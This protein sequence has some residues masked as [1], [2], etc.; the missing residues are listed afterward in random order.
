MTA[1]NDRGNEFSDLP[2]GRHTVDD[3]LTTSGT[4]AVP[5]CMVMVIDVGWAEN[6]CK[7]DSRGNKIT[8]TAILLKAIALAQRHHPAS[9]TELLP[10][11]DSVTYDDIVAGFTVEREVGGKLTVFFGEITSPETKSIEEIAQE[12]STCGRE[13]IELN[14]S[15]ALQAGFATMPLVLRRLILKLGRNFPAFR[16]KAQKSTFGVT[17]LGK[18]GVSMI[19][20]PCICTSTFGIGAIEDSVV[21]RGHKVGV[22]KTL[23]ISFNYDQRILNHV[24]A[25]SFFREV[26]QLLE[27]GLRRWLKPDCPPAVYSDGEGDLKKSA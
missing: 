16:L 19:V 6:L 13:P 22:R 12:L 8:I 11:G 18:Y 3:L 17:T 4:E 15:F 23:P 10:F 7:Q 1:E 27:G 5:A 25:A 26:C 21:V 20:C 9:R 2:V 14:P 24:E